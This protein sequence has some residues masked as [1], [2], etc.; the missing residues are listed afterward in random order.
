MIIDD[1]DFSPSIL[2][3]RNS[4]AVFVGED[5]C[6]TIFRKLEIEA[7]IGINEKI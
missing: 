2:A 6:R 3:E 4:T 1:I 7:L 5:G